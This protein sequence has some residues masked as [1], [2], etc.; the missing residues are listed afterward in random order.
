MIWLNNEFIQ[1][2]TDILRNEMS[3]IVET[4]ITRIGFLKIWTDNEI[5]SFAK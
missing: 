2:E 3:E 1:K 4:E 5:F